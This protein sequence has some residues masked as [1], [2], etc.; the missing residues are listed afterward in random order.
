MANHDLWA[1][2]ALAALAFYGAVVLAMLLAYL[3]GWGGP[4]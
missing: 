3:G 4:D 1:I 2:M